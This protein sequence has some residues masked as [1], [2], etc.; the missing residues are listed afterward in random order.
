M[1]SLA[2]GKNRITQRG[3]F[4]RR[5]LSASTNLMVFPEFVETGTRKE[6][7]EEIVYHVAMK[8]LWVVKHPVDA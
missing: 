1:V 4:S 8:N 6:K 2:G 5:D 7:E 3:L